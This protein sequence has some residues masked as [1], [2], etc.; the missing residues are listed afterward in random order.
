MVDHQSRA[1]NNNRGVGSKAVHRSS[2]G[3]YHKANKGVKAVIL[4][5]CM[6][7]VWVES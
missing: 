1:D 5:F 7:D 4:N 2:V 3:V 6:D